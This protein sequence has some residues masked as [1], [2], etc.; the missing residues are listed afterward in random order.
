MMAIVISVVPTGRW[1]KGEERLMARPR[2]ASQSR[3]CA[4]R[5]RQGEG[6]TG[7]GAVQIEPGW[8]G[9]APT[10]RAL[11]RSEAPEGHETRASHTPSSTDTDSETRAGASRW[12]SPGHPENF[13]G[14]DAESVSHSKPRVP[15]RMP[16]YP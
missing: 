7:R 13:A 5:G 3:R 10:R 15:R 11:V 4:K 8:P 14:K 9:R 16:G 1:M 6:E 2:V 12:S